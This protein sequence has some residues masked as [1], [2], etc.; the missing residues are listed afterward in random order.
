VTYHKELNDI[1]EVLFQVH[2]FHNLN[3][4]LVAVEG[5]DNVQREKTYFV[6]KYVVEYPFE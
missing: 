2:F 3:N 6:L 5:F 4:V 1:D